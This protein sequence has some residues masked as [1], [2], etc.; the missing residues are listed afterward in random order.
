MFVSEK[1]RF[2]FLHV[3]KNAG[4]SIH[5]ALAELPGLKNSWNGKTKHETLAH[6]VTSQ[7]RRAFYYSLQNK[8]WAKSAKGIAFAAARKIN[9]IS[10]FS[11]DDY[12]SFGIVR[13]PWDRTLS[14]YNYLKKYRPRPEI[15]TITDFRH[16][17]EAAREQECPWIKSLHGLKQQLSFFTMGNGKINSFIGHYE[18]L[19]EDIR[20]VEES[21]GLPIKLGHSNSSGSHLL[22]YRKYYTG[23]MEAIVADL[24]MDDIKTLGY[25]FENRTPSKRISYYTNFM[26]DDESLSRLRV[27]Y[28]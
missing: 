12:Y 11:P 22:D 13:N 24:F 4:T 19:M 9:L 3:P 10:E 1:Y 16:F 28:Q 27:N 26:V 25:N 7:N 18:Y 21:I 23:D 2:I 6:Y 8:S 14:F 20:I 5:K 15:D 17:L